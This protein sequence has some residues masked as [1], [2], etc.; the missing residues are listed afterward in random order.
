MKLRNHHQKLRDEQDDVPYE[1]VYRVAKLKLI[2][3][4]VQVDIVSETGVGPTEV[5][6]LCEGKLQNGDW[7][8]A[9]AQLIREGH[10]FG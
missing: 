2:E 1:L 8:T 10:D 4:K 5:R 9:I 6:L 3:N 7:Q